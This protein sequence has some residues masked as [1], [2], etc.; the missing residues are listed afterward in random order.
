MTKAEYLEQ[1]NRKLRVLP[2]G[3]RQDALDYYDGYLSDSEDEAAAIDQLGTPGEV[4]ANILANYVN[5]TPPHEHS[6]TNKSGTRGVKT[7][8]AIILAIFALPVG[9]PI[10]IALAMIPFSLFIALFSVF[11]A[12]GATVLGMFAAGLVG[13]VSFP[14]VAAHDFGTA[15]I[16]GGMSLVSIG[17]GILCLHLIPILRRGFPMISR[18]AAQKIVS[19]KSGIRRTY[20]GR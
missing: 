10:I 8:W 15:L 13:I 9:L 14:F 12:I 2:S 7:A 19:L 5:K 3:E 20:H 18:F 11:I 17:I 16:S 4:A 6:D 1:L